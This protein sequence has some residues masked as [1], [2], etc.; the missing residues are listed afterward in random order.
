[1]IMI[2]RDLSGIRIGLVGPL[3]LPHGGMSNQTRQLAQLLEGSGTAVEVVRT[4]APYAPAWVASLRGVRAVF[5]LVPYFFRLWRCAGRVDLMHVMA[6]SGWA[7]HLFAAPAIWTASLR[8]VPVV[9]N[10][11][12]GEA[13][14]FLAH[15]PRMFKATMARASVL[16]VPTAFLAGVFAH[17]GIEAR[18]VPNIIDTGRFAR[19]EPAMMSPAPHLI[20]TRN[21]EP[22]YDNGT[23]IRAFAIVRDA[24]PLARLSIAGAGPER[25]ALERLVIDLGLRGAVSFTGALDR[26]AI[27]ALI[28]SAD[29]MINASRADNTPNA[30]LEALATGVPVVTTDVGGIPFLVQHESTALLVSAG[31]HQ[32]LADAAVRCL[33]DRTLAR[34]LVANGWAMVEGFTWPAVRSVLAGVYRDAMLGRSLATEA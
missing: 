17:H 18:I 1:M 8:G 13:S 23:A 24:F 28:R 29:L 30:I 27:A 20:V 19:K 34:Q 9:V 31:D 15:S 6:N 32:A 22:I 25:A 7:W 26:D 4:N 12:G 5:R 10:Y 16:I 3:P 11:R 33:T 21:L 14:A 2:Q